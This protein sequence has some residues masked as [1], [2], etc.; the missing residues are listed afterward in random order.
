MGTIVPRPGSL[1]SSGR[2]LPASPVRRVGTRATQKG[3]QVVRGQL[4]VRRHPRWALG[5]LGA[6]SGVLNPLHGTVRGDGITVESL[7]RVADPVARQ[8]VELRAFAKRNH[9]G[10]GLFGAR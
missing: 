10:C 9:P 6:L 1:G 7:E 4:G 3:L 2:R 5:I 8:V